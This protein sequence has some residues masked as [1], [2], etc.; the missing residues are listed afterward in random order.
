LTEQNPFEVKR[1]A[2]YG[3]Q[4]SKKFADRIESTAGKVKSQTAPLK[5]KSPFCIVATSNAGIAT[6]AKRAHRYVKVLNE[7]QLIIPTGGGTSA[8]MTMEI[9]G[10]IRV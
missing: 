4:L 7:K 2:F 1:N 10:I 8:S 9:Q 3:K 5:R 6:L